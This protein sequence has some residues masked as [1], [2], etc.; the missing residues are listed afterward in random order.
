MEQHTLDFIAPNRYPSE[1]LITIYRQT[2]IVIATDTDFGISVTNA[3]ELIA[4]EV[5][6]RFRVDPHKMIF[7]EQYR[8][9]KTDQTTDLVKFDSYGKRGFNG[10]NWSH[11]PLEDFKKMVE[12]A[13]QVE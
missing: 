1:C 9:G 8:P 6:K 11:I 4:S 2:G 7:I 10:A 5:V 12:I 13:E 3:C